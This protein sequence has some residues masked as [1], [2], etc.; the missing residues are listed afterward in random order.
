MSLRWPADLG[1]GIPV[2]PRFQAAF[3]RAQNVLVESVLR[4]LSKD[5]QTTIRERTLPLECVQRVDRGPQKV[6]FLSIRLNV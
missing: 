5:L 2:H 4:A 3:L 6:S 1:V